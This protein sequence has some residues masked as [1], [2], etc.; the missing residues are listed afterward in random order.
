MGLY[1]RVT[2]QSLFKEV[3]FTLFKMQGSFI[4]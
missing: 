2:Y 1:K 4:I 3:Y